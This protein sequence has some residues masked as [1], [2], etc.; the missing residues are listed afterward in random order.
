MTKKQTSAL[1]D[2]LRLLWD[3]GL[4]LGHR[5]S[6]V[7]ECRESAL[8]DQVYTTALLES[9]ILYGPT[10]LFKGMKKKTGPDSVWSSTEFFEAKIEEQRQRY[11]KFNDTGFNLEPN[12]KEGPGG[13]RDFQ[14]I[15]WLKKRHYR[16]ATLR[17]LVDEKCLTAKEY[18]EL[19]AG[20]EFLWKIRFALH[21][22]TGRAEDRLLFNPPDPPRPAVRL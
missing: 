15:A 3:I 4:K 14:T 19:I 16:T 8:E 7:E 20:Q 6:T 1:E 5:V 2:F 11:A 12:V 17:E 22:L 21:I 13:L 9:R 10:Y 18:K